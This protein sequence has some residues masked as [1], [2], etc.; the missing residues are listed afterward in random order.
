MFRYHWI[1]RACGNPNLTPVFDL[2]IQPLAN[3]FTKLA[4]DQP[5][6]APLKVLHCDQCTLAQLSVVVDPQ[7]LYSTYNYV[8]SR[9]QTMQDHF[10]AL[11]AAI[12]QEC[13]PDSLVEIGSNDGCF[14]KFCK[15]RGVHAV[16]GIDPAENLAP[17]YDST[18]IISLCSL[19]DANSA[20][21][22]KRA[23]PV[24]DVIVAR[25]VFA[26]CDDWHGFVKNLDTLASKDTLIVIE[27]PY[28]VDTLERVEFDQVYH[29]H[30]SYVTVKSVEHLL[31][32]TVFHLHKVLKFEVHGGA[33]A[34]MLRRNDCSKY[35]DFSVA[36]YIAGEHIIPEVWWKFDQAVRRRIDRVRKEVRHLAGRGKKVCGFGASAKS[37]VWLQACE[38][39]QS[40]INFI[41]DSTSWK[42]GKCSPGT[43]I[44]IVGESELK[45]S[46]ADYAINFAWQYEAEIKK[47]LQGWIE[48]GG[49]LIN[50]H[51]T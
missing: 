16:L 49:Q 2:G 26:H 17:V 47:K 10:E 9:S 4:D 33:I 1:C 27:V 40:D 29:E 45:N 14:L 50:P 48:G 34:L 51:Q 8:T 5:G 44:P 6:F 46:T 20:A 41:C 38:F 11:W 24:V 36:E 19:F 23:I 35:P 43:A 37:T 28:L 7:V 31:Q 22:A 18:G 13:N 32:G 30:L 12:Q 21:I 42:Q 15:E 39:T 25:H 3:A